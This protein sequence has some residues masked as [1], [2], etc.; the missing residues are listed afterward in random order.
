V[1]PQPGKAVLRFLDA[2]LHRFPPSR[3]ALLAVAGLFLL[4]ILGGSLLAYLITIDSPQVSRLED[5][6]PPIGTRIYAD[7]GEVVYEFAGEKRILIEADAIPETLRNAIIATEDARFYRHFGIDPRSI[8]RAAVRDLIS[9][10]FA[11]GASTIT[12][13]LARNL[14]LRPDKTPWRKIQ[15]AVL[16]LQIEKAYTKEEILEFYCN[17]IYMGHGRYGLEAAARFYFG[18]GVAA[19]APPEAALLAGILQRPEALSPFRF[20]DRALAKRNHV[21]NRMAREGYLTREEAEGH[22]QAPLELAEPQAVENVAPYFVEMVRQYLE[23]AYGEESVFGEGMEVYS[24]LNLELQAAANEAIRA[25]LLALD[26]RQGWRGPLRNLRDGENGLPAEGL[27]AYRDPA[28]EEGI[29]PGATLPGVITRVEG[30]GAEVRIGEYRSRIGPEAIEWTGAARPADLFR[31]GDVA[32]FRVEAVDAP[33]G[34]VR[35]ALEQEPEVEGALVALDPASGEIRAMVGGYDFRRSQF[36][37]AVQSLRQSGSAFK[38]I[39]YAA[40]LANGFRPSDTFLDEPTVFRRGADAPPYQPENY[41]REYAGQTTVRGALEESRN[42][43]SVKLLSRIG[44]DAAVEMARRM[45]IR[46]P[47]EPVP[48]L[49]LGA[50]EVTLLELTSAY[51][52]FPNLGIRVEPHFLRYVVGG[53]GQLREEAQPE[54]R[55]ALRAD[56]AYVMTHMLRGVIE[57]GTGKNARVLDAPLAGKTGTTDDLADGWFIGYSPSLVVGVWIGYD[58]K[59]SLGESETGARAALPIWIQF[60]RQVIAAAPPEPFQRPANVVLVPI[61]RATGLRASIDTGCKEVFL[62]AFVRGTEPGAYCSAE[63]H[64]RLTL[65]YFLQGYSVGRRNELMIPA[66]DLL[67]LLARFPHD[68]GIADSARTLTVRRD[69]RPELLVP[70]PLTRQERES[71]LASLAARTIA[72][73]EPE[74]GFW[75]WAA[76][77]DPVGVDGRPANLLDFP[78]GS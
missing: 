47:I 32:L 46:S 19:L 56:L 21:L 27:A 66:G 33:G 45:G 4:A 41:V 17:Q 57:S 8:L 22:G 20:P 14:F 61:D 13:Q 2:L 9:L 25:G 70:L 1:D 3:R 64:F 31:A 6:R 48:S 15:E 67:P 28:W 24:T 73:T 39:L 18:K 7:N 50:S 59:R 71:V 62:E 55:E 68:L 52:I 51:G 54:V 40:A 44:I 43:V 53:D 5:Y 26:K 34:S 72:A 77:E 30:G 35:L 42:I 75:T 69:G 76:G 23:S 38:P 29:P 78:S 16:A 58:V 74:A 60:F 36:N 12:Q 65:P 11:Q 63:E 10:R 37:R 49:A